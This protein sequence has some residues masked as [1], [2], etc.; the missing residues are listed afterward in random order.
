[1]RNSGRGSHCGKSW[2]FSAPRAVEPTSVHSNKAQVEDRE[3]R[4][5]RE[6]MKRCGS[7][8]CP[9]PARKVE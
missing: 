8:R 9:P 5:A 1:M 3:V 2:R 6:T 4:P 7:V